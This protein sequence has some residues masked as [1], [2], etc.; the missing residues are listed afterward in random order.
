MT[1]LDEIVL[2]SISGRREP[3]SE[4]PEA[5]VR[6]VSAAELA[7]AIEAQYPLS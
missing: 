6:E 5:A 3:L 4:H 7:E 1:R 2:L